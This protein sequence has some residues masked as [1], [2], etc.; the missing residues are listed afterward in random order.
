MTS[1]RA[2]GL[3]SA[4]L[5]SV[6][7]VGAIAADA[8]PSRPP[9]R[10]TVT[11]LRAQY[12]PP[13]KSQFETEAEYRTRLRKPPERAFL[14]RLARQSCGTPAASIGY[15]AER[16]V[17]VLQLSGES[18]FLETE[19]ASADFDVS[20]VGSSAAA[21]RQPLI[22]YESC[23]SRDLGSVPMTNAFGASVMVERSSFAATALLVPRV[24]TTATTDE[25]WSLDVRMDRQYARELVTGF[26]SLDVEVEA[27]LLP[28]ERGLI[29][30][31]GRWGKA[32][33]LR[34]PSQQELS[35]RMLRASIR[36]VHLRRRGATAPALTIP[37]SNVCDR[38]EVERLAGEERAREAA[39]AA[40]ASRRTFVAESLAQANVRRLED[41]WRQQLERSRLEQQRLDSA[42]FGRLT[43]EQEARRDSLRRTR[44]GRPAFWWGV[45]FGV[46]SDVMRPSA[47]NELM[48]GAFGLFGGFEVGILRLALRP[49]DFLMVPTADADPV[50]RHR[51]GAEFRLKRAL[52]SHLT[53][54]A[55]TFQS[56]GTPVPT[57]TGSLRANDP[58][59]V[60]GL[61]TPTTVGVRSGVDA[62]VFRNRVDVMMTFYGAYR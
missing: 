2:R 11:A 21:S 43:P 47:F 4:I 10:T 38:A 20:Q 57:Y 32:A 28:D 56:S 41:A 6:L 60:V 9:V 18:R 24:D 36:A 58:Y 33:E 14:I 44:E 12:K 61:H 46:G 62:R 45:E 49:L 34:S 39:A 22:V 17:L 30:L 5:S 35:I 23:V 25:G 15:D 3:P 42:I 16:G 8:Q 13:A 27:C 48:T 53:L 40:A 29:P 26:R 7:L 59:V 1:H 54:G 19:G 51:W 55:G 31:T 50:Y 37:M 52:S